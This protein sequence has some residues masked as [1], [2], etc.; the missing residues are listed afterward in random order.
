MMLAGAV[1]GLHHLPTAYLI[2]SIPDPDT[3]QQLNA[4]NWFLRGVSTM[5]MSLVAEYVGRISM[6]VNRNPQYIIRD[7]LR[8]RP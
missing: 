5:F 6:S 4:S 1:Y 3:Y 7:I 8:H 2:P